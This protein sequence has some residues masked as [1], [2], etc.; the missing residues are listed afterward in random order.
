MDRKTE[1][2]SWLEGLAQENWRVFHSDNEV[3]NI[4]KA[5]LELLKE[6]DEIIQRYKKTDGWLAVHGWKW[7]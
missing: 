2:M 6:Q 7:N 5:A 1:V 3:Q 4:A